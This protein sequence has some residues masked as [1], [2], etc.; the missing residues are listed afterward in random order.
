MNTHKSAKTEEFV[1]DLMPNATEEEIEEAICNFQ[2]YL[3]VVMKITDRL[4]QEGKKVI[5]EPETA[6]H[7]D[8]LISK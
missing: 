4:E 1:R 7:R 5:T 6:T 8:N 2:E 3:G